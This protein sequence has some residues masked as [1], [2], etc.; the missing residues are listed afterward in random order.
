MTNDLLFRVIV[1]INEAIRAGRR[2]DEMTRA[3]VSRREATGVA[4]LVE[5][6]AALEAAPRRGD[7]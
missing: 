7:S 1:W 4:L 6:K 3:H 5:L 2:R